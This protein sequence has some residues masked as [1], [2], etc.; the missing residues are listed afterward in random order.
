MIMA[1]ILLN[2]LLLV[3]SA[4]LPASTH[5]LWL[6]ASE[7]RTARLYFGEFQ[8][9]LR[10]KS[11]GRLDDITTVKAWCQ[12]NTDPL[13]EL[14]T[15]RN[16]QFIAIKPCN[17]SG[18]IVIESSGDKVIDMSKHGGSGT[19]RPMRYARFS[20]DPTAPVLTLD[21]V[22]SAEPGVLRVFFRTQP[23]AKA[24]VTV[25]AENGWEQN[26][27]SD[28]QGK[29]RV[30]TPWPG[31]YVVRA[32]HAEPQA[33]ELAGQK[34]DSLRHSATLTLAVKP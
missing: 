12:S 11:P 9:N 31:Q 33:G 2:V 19:V 26:K 23:L 28:E 6:E 14:A 1:T 18:A 21:V 13:A 10:E 34:Y 32:V 5:Y 20:A 3:L 29:V 22:P 30:S 15:S 25:Y 16:E 8:Q 4:A 7:G 27:L 24:Q 17:A